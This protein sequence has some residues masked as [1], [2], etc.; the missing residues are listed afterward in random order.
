MNERI[1]NIAIGIALAA[2]SLA[3]LVVAIK[4]GAHP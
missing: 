4:Y 1:R 3:T 2:F